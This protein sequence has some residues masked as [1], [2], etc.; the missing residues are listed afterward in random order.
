MLTCAQACPY[1]AIMTKMVQIRNMPEQLHRI[2]KA[3][4]A[5]EGLSL[6]DYLL[7]ELKRFASRPTP[8]EMRQ[9]L[10]D[11]RPVEPTLAPAEAIRQEREGR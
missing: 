5:L 9:R 3:R 6:S 4:S 10:L 7:I 11:R 8:R 2:L 1:D